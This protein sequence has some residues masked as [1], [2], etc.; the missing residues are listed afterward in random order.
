[1]KKLPWIL[2]IILSVYCSSIEAQT[3]TVGEVFDLHS[4]DEYGVFIELEGADKWR[5]VIVKERQDFADKRKIIYNVNTYQYKLSVGY[6][7]VYTQDTVTYYNLDSIY[8]DG[9]GTHDTVIYERDM[10]SVIRDSSWNQTFKDS[11][12]HDKYGTLINLTIDDYQYW[13]G[14]H[15][16]YCWAYKGI[17]IVRYNYSG[18]GSS[19]SGYMEHLEY[20]IKNGVLCGKRE[21]FPNSLDDI[22]IKSIQM[23]PNPASD[24]ILIK[25][26]DHFGY[27][28]FDLQGREIS[29]GS[30]RGGEQID[31]KGIMPGLYY[32]QLER[33]NRRITYKFTIQ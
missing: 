32:I 2:N 16:I 11:V 1:M 3:L 6:E 8:F 20:Y 18:S 26:E 15:M 22:D 33:G 17:G 29:S 14:G 25:G 19:V 7:W 4:G 21:G 9:F 27:R 13:E 31:L 28:I 23:Y 10:D 12:Y 24:Y 5:H 30:T